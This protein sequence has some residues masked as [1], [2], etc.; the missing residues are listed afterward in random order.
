[1]D[2]ASRRTAIARAKELVRQGNLATTDQDVRFPDKVI[3]VIESLELYKDGKKCELKVN[4]QVC[5]Y[6][7][8]TRQP[9]QEHCRDK[10]G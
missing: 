5:R 3:P 6:I 4:G 8:R 10:H 9:V 2:L 7:R 1:M